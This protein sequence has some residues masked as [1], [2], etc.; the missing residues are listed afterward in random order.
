V[1][2]A[3]LICRGAVF[4]ILSKANGWYIVQKDPDGLGQIIPDNTKSGWVP[5]GKSLTCALLIFRLL[6]RTHITY[7]SRFSHDRPWRTTTHLPRSSPFTSNLH[8][9]D[10]LPRCSPHGLH[11]ED[12]RRNRRKRRSSSKGIQEILSLVLCV[13]PLICLADD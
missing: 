3:R 2:R 1:K 9:I 8:H 10:L 11:E 13:C 4:V 6:T 7:I 5:A 12:K